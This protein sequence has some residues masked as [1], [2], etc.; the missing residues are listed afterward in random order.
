MD[1]VRAMALCTALLANCA[2][3]P[4]AS[5]SGDEEDEELALRPGTLLAEAAALERVAGGAAK[6]V[7]GAHCVQM[8]NCRL[9]VDLVERSCLN[10]NRLHDL[11][12]GYLGSEPLMCC[13][14]GFYETGGGRPTPTYPTPGRPTGSGGGGGGGIDGE[15]ARPT[16]FNPGC[17]R[18]IISGTEAGLGAQPW[19]V[20]IAFKHVRS[21]KFTYPCCGSIV[22]PKTVLTAAHCALAK[23]EYYKLSSVVAGEY[24][25]RGSPDCTRDYCSLPEQ[26]VPVSHVI[27]HPGY[28][29]NI[30]KH[31]IALLILKSPLNYSLA[32]QPVCISES[33]QNDVQRTDRRARLVGW[34]RLPG[35]EAA[36]PRQQQ[37][38]LPLLPLERCAELYRR[39]LPITGRQL[40]AGGEEGRDACSGF[41]GAPLMMQGYNA[42]YYQIGMASFGSDKCGEG[43]V[44]SVYTNVMKYVDWIKSNLVDS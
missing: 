15:G 18:R 40:C 21:N 2:F 43:N 1:A 14:P 26:V 29:R 25:A 8:R 22:T 38:E 16:A 11:V 4:V 24:D 36:S 13:P 5:F 17:G 23:S 20:R 3:R 7:G 31:D 28:Q 41:G 34:G 39:V 33:L 44:P 27:V 10:T 12:C 30:F 42:R 37:L 19:T 35:Q 6:C 32:A 9:L